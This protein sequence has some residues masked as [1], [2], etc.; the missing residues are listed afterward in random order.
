MKL[1]GKTSTSSIYEREDGKK[2]VIYKENSLYGV[3]VYA[4]V[5]GSFETVASRC[6]YNEARKIASEMYKQ[7]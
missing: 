6:S 1:Y 7:R 2:V 4:P 3:K 5:H